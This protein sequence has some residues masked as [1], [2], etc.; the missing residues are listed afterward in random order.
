[1]S[2]Q[3]LFLR[4]VEIQD[5]YIKAQA[6]FEETQRSNPSLW[7]DPAIQAIPHTESISSTHT[8]DEPKAKYELP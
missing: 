5:E 8:S 6:M 1:M 7:S 2:C 4:S 3:P